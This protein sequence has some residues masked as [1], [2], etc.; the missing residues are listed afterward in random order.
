MR[1]LIIGGTG[2]DS[3]ATRCRARGNLHLGCC[4]SG[5]GNRRLHRD[6]LSDRLSPRDGQ[7]HF[8]PRAD[9][10]TAAIGTLF[11]YSSARASS[12]GGTSIPSALAVSR[13]IVN[14]YLVGC[15]TG[16]SAGFAPHPL[17]LLRAYCERP[18]RYRAAEQRGELAPFHSIT[19]SASAST[20]GGKLRPTVFAVLRLITNSNLVGCTTGRSAGFSP[21]RMRAT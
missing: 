5:S 8:L 19:S 2:H 9:I 6:D 1:R 3:I 17:A 18:R 21:L 11:N 12:I 16:R 4:G 15:C 14:S 20:V 10:C 7:S 13:L